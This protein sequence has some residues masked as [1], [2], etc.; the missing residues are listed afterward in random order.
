MPNG[1][2]CKYLQHVHREFCTTGTDDK[3]GVAHCGVRTHDNLTSSFRVQIC[4]N[5]YTL[6]RTI[7]RVQ[8]RSD[9]RRL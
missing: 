9:Q 4:T 8:V 7:G 2:V 1:T 6:I 5:E 3:I